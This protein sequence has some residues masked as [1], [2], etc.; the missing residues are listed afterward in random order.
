MSEKQKRNESKTMNEVIVIKVEFVKDA[1]SH[2]AKRSKEVTDIISQ[3]IQLSHKRGRPSQQQQ[4]M[5]D[6]A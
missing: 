6:V 5:E 2:S 3:M 1:S 4:E